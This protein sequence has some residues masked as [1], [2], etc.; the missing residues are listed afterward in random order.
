ML[1]LNNS[2]RDTHQRLLI[3]VDV[4]RLSYLVRC[5]KQFIEIQIPSATNLTV[6]LA[7]GPL[8]T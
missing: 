6:Q 5:L 1:P 3:P 2:A 7:A 4:W 8:L